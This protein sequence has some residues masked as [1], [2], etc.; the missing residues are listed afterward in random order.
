MSRRAAAGPRAPGQRSP[1]IP[2]GPAGS[3]RAP[4]GEG[5]FEGSGTG[6]TVGRGSPRARGWSGRIIPAARART[7]TM[8]QAKP[9]S[10]TP[11]G[12]HQK[13]PSPQIIPGSSPRGRERLP[14]GDG[15]NLSVLS[16]LTRYPL[17]GT[18]VRSPRLF[19]L[20]LQL[21]IQTSEPPRSRRGDAGSW[22]NINHHTPPPPPGGDVEFDSRPQS[23]RCGA[24][25]V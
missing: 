5:G 14:P 10:R 4:L 23:G 16:K 8:G 12:T 25:R 6:G 17:P 21:N 2:Q 3:C 1:E 20:P 13:H 11:R 15:L 18:P 9:C 24:P 19:S 22:S 7:R